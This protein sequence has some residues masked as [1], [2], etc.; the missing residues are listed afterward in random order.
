MSA[1]TVVA[2]DSGGAAQ[3]LKELTSFRWSFS[4]DSPCAYWECAASGVPRGSWVHRLEAALNGSPLFS[5]RMDTQVWEQGQ[6]GSRCRLTARS[7]TAALLDNEAAPM[8]YQNYS[9][10]QLLFDH[11]YPYGLTG[12]ALSGGTLSQITC[13][14][15]MSHWDFLQFYCRLQLGYLPWVNEEGTLVRQGDSGTEHSFSAGEYQSFALTLDRT[16]MISRLYVLDDAGQ[17]RPVSNTFAQSF[18]AERTEYYAP[19]GR[20]SQ[21]LTQAAGNRF[22]E[23]QLDCFTGQLVLS[24]LHRFR[25]GQR[26]SVSG[27]D[28]SVSGLELTGIVLEGDE[29]GL[30]TRLTLSDPAAGNI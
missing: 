1:L 30:R 25:L 10:S 21:N 15:G 2:R 29:S 9:F 11:G 7:G 14:K 23:R 24:G 12:S 17:Y 6:T 22:R 16:R 26:V 5:G 19:P 20:W 28:I 18:L 4:K 8:V 3:E 13:A 27:R